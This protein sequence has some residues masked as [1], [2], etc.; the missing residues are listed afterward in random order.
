MI[1]IQLITGVG[2][3]VNL[4]LEAVT[5]GFVFKYDFWLPQNASDFLQLL[6]DPFE[7]QTHTLNKRSVSNSEETYGF[8]DEQQEKFEK[9]L[10]DADV[11]ESGTVM[12]D[13]TNDGGIN[14]NLATTRWLVYKALAEISE[15][16]VF[17][18]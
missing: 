5:I 6:S 16:C 9:H 12:D 7:P 11:V 10:S 2:L 8:D 15:K 1:F 17:Q 4:E 3:P 13:I 18:K 14:N